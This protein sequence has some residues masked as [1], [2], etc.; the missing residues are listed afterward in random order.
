MPS[1]KAL[2][3]PDVQA[4]IAA[5][6]R[7][8]MRPTPSSLLPGEAALELDMLVKKSIETVVLNTIDI[9]RISVVPRGEVT[10]GFRPFT[11][12]L[13]GLYLQPT[14]RE[15]VGQNLR[16]NEQ[17]TLEAES[18]THEARLEDYIV[19]ALVD[20]DAHAE[21]L[22]EL[23]GQ[24]VAHLQTYL[25]ESGGFRN[26]SGQILGMLGIDRARRGGNRLQF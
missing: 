9:P 26:S 14:Q 2:L 11:L 13:S 25:S 15:I 8:R 4:Q 23:V 17:F 24:A 10:A 1:S 19:Y 20:Y 18:A 22:Y 7:Q 6:V 12:E 5:E 3:R 21:L 16:T